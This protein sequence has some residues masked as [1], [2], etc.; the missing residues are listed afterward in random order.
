[1]AYP[2]WFY[3]PDRERPPGWVEPFIAVIAA[4]ASS[5]T[6]RSVSGLTSDKVLAVL[7]PALEALGYRV[8]RARR[9]ASRSPCPS[10]SV[11]RAEQECAKTQ[12]RYTTISGV[13]AEV[14]AKDGRESA[15][16][17]RQAS[18]FG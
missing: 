1:M 14:E 11:I 3:Y 9:K 7:P 10:S 15:A 16:S 2:D 12:T 13:A 6:S 4:S 18:A 8:E 5:I 17:I